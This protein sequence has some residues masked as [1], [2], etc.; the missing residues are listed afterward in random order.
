MTCEKSRELF[1]DYLG[2]EL[3]KHEGAQLRQHLQACPGCRQELA[4]LADTRSALRFAWPDE[5]MPQ[6]LTFD[7]PK[8][9]A[10]KVDAPL[11]WFGLPRSVVVSLS[12]AA[13]FLMCLAGL[14]L[15]RT[16][17][18]IRQG[19][20]RVSFGQAPAAVS[21]EAPQ[22]SGQTS[23]RLGQGEVQAMIEQALRR[24]EGSQ[25]ARLQQ[26]VLEVKSEVDASRRAD[27]M[28]IAKQMN[29]LENTQS[30][31]WKE[32]ARNNSYLDTLARDF[33][34]KTSAQQ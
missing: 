3:G 31:V 24:L 22:V 28:R 17:I 21:N 23:A 26:A 12:A 34:L 7:F 8:R 29:Y 5:E 30:V 18:E 6:H 11:S 1:V 32:A 19:T 25:N 33:Y 14:A 9:R 2:E 16:Q 15:F 20:F 13:C 4:Q 10:S 27:L